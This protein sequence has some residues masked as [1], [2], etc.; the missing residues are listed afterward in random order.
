MGLG[1]PFLQNVAGL[2]FF[3]LLGTGA[4]QGFSLMPDFSTYALLTVWEDQDSADHFYRNNTLIQSYQARAANIRR[5]SLANTASHGLWSGLNP[6]VP[7]ET[8]PFKKRPVAI[9]TRATLRPQRLLSFWRAVPQASK[10]IETAQG[11]QFY[12]GIGEWPFIQQATIS[13]WN[14]ME[15]VMQFAYKDKAHKEIVKQTKKERWY[16]EDLFARFLVVN[17]EQLQ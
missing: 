3:K 2:S 1:F 14:S 9:I 5:L 11:V 17:D 7:T 16:K 8:Q 10:A 12:K 13:I 15:E 6:F 4:G